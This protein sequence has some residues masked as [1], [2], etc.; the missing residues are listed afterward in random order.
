[1]SY[2]PEALKLA[3]EWETFFNANDEVGAAAAKQKLVD[4]CGGNVAIANRIFDSLDPELSGTAPTPKR[5]GKGKGLF[6]QA[7][8]VSRTPETWRVLKNYPLYEIS[9]HG[10]VRALDR[11]HP[12]DWLKPRRKWY[13]GMCPESVV[14]RD[15]EGKR[16]ERFIGK[17]LVSAGFMPRPEWMEDL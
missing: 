11:A 15:H 14:L 12:N 2:S 3:K 13:R 5:Q 6:R 17:L 1:M 16:C 9:S 8:R 10:R 4:L 7:R